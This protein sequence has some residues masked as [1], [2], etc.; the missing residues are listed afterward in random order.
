MKMSVIAYPCNDI[1]RCS[2]K[3]AQGL[4]RG[5]RARGFRAGIFPLPFPVF[6]VSGGIAAGGT[7][8]SQDV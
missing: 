6:H 7:G 2:R 4:A 8:A 1:T 3:S 5:Y